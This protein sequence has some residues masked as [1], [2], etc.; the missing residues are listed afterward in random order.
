M[1]FSAYKNN[2]S[3]FKRL[4]LHEH[5][6]ITI[7]CSCKSYIEQTEV[8]KYLGVTIDAALKWD[9]HI[10]V[11]IKKLR[12]FYYV[13]KQ[14]REILPINNLFQIYHGLVESLLPYGIIGWGGTIK[15]VIKPLEIVQKRQ[16][17]TKIVL[18]KVYKE[19]KILVSNN[20]LHAY[21]TRNKDHNIINY[22]QVRKSAGQ[23]NFEYLAVRF[24]NILPS[25]IKTNPL[26][27]SYRKKLLMWLK[28]CPRSVIHKLF[29][30]ESL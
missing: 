6:C 7:N 22:P 13:F 18:I 19:K 30:R 11:I 10:M 16:I 8:I 26:Y 14:L 15:T 20:P 21:S 23:R 25:N 3:N 1:T 17:F 12:G 28:T 5:N 2:L 27:S 4:P 24:Y 9:E 29:L